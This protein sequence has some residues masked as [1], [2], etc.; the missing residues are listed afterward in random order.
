[1]RAA[2][3]ETKGKTGGREVE[4]DRGQGKEEGGEGDVAKK[5]TE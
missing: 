3:A 5:E 2:R 1:M 4:Q